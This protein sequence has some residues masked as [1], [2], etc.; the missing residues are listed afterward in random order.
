MFPQKKGLKSNTAL[1][2]SQNE[3]KKWLQRPPL[4]L[5][6]R[7]KSEVRVFYFKLSICPNGI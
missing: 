2:M 7:N 3:T 6:A 4:A 1:G 5:T